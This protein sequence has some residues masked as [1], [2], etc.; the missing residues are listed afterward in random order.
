MDGII[1][2]ACEVDC[3]GEAVLEFLLLLP[4]KDLFIMALQNAWQIIAIAAWY[5]WW[6]RRKLV[7]EETI[8]SAYQISMG[9]RALTANFVIA[10]YPNA[11]MKR[12][13]LDLAPCGFCQ[14]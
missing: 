10:S 6:E 5:L 14:T 11:T 4:D 8:Q 7:H 3:D 2:R 9:I 12:G 13:G 1:N